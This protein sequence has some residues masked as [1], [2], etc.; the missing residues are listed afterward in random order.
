MNN[1][2]LTQPPVMKTGMLIRRRAGE[3][4][5]A[6][7]NP[8]MTTKFWFTKGSGRLEVGKRVEWAWEM[9]NISVPV[10]AKAIE[11]NTRIV[12]EWKGYSARTTVEWMFKALPDGTTFVTITESGLPATVIRSS[13]RWLIRHRDSRSRSRVRRHFSSTTSD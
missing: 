9:Y 3:V 2:Q 13:N 5:E 1:L 12:I 7:V 6:F 4:F 8:D 11:P 10:T